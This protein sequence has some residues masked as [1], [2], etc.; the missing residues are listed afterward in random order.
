MIATVAP[1][2]PVAVYPVSATDDINALAVDAV[3]Q[4][5]TVRT[6]NNPT[7]YELFAKC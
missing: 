6:A 2:R 1:P 3:N 7:A 4:A 5:F